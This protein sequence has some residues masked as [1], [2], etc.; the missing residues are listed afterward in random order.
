V[1][2]VAVLA[3]G[4][5][6]RVAQ[7]TGPDLP[8]ALL[9]VADRPFIDFKLASL[10]AE[11]IHEVVLLIGHGA[12]SIEMHVGSGQRYGLRV[13]CQSDAPSLLGTGGAVR[14]ALDLLGDVFWVTYGDTYLRAPME[15]IETAFFSRDLG[16]MMTVLRNRDLWDRSNVEVRENLVVKCAKGQPPGTFE[17]IDYGLTVLRREVLESFPPDSRFDLEDVFQHLITV[18]SLGAYPVSKRFYEIGTPEGY[19]ETDAFLRTAMEWNR[20]VG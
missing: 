20:L 18:R 16:G 7:V 3:G 9:P 5:G 12:R 6:T 11:G 17:Y 1:R 10:A 14:Q 4:L 8:K 15:G 13:T 19:K 2:P